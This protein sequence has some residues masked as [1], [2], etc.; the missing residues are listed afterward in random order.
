VN[1]EAGLLILRGDANSSVKLF[2]SINAAG[3]KAV[4]FSYDNNKYEAENIAG[5]PYGSGSSGLTIR[6]A[7]ISAGI[8]LIGYR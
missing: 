6:S 2:S 5:T 7:A 3:Q 1:D 4:I 8:V